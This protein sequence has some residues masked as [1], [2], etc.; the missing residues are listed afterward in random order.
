MATLPAI[1]V[2]QQFGIIIVGDRKL[3]GSMSKLVKIANQYNPGQSN[4]RATITFKYVEPNRVTGLVTFENYLSL[5]IHPK[6][7]LCLY[8][9]IFRSAHKGV[10][11]AELQKLSESI[12]VAS[13][14]AVNKVEPHQAGYYFHV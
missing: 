10:T 2:S 3:L 8:F 13:R 5:T 4:E 9:R 6:D 12:V 14:G 11:L 1:P 7:G